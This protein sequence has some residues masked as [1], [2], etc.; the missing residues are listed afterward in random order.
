[1]HDPGFIRT[2]AGEIFSAMNSR[3]LSGLARYLADD[4][5][6]DFPG[7]GCISGQK[8]ILLFLKVL[9]RKYPR[10]MFTVEDMLIEGDRACAVWSNEGEDS[11]GTPY[12]N[13]GVTVVRIAKEKIIFISD[14]FKDTSFI[15]AAK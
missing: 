15:A 6:F 14:Y 5:M 13:R 4:A 10:L 7:A 12:K 11:H 9:F 3:D 8:K 1:M 2:C